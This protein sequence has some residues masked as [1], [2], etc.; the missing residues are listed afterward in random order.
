MP[1]ACRFIVVLAAVVMT[2]SNLRAA[3]AA[4]DVVAAAEDLRL[5]R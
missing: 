2:F 3:A 1:L 4:C 5:A